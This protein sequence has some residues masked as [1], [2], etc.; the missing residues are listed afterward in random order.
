MNALLYSPSGGGKTTNATLVAAPRRKKNLLICSDNSS[1]VL[2]NFER[3]NLDIQAVSRVQ[4]FLD[5]YQTGAAAKKYDNIIVDN[6]SDLFDM[7]ILEL[8]D[9]KKYKDM[10]QAY[11]LVYQSLKRLTRE[12]TRLD[13]NTVFTAWSNMT[14]ITRPDGSLAQRLE[15]KI[16]SKVLDNIAGL[17]NVVG[18]INTREKDGKRIWYYSLK[19][20]PLVMAKDQIACR[21]WCMPEDLF[22]EEKA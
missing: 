3:P 9:S 11:Q 15:P 20:G 18:Y 10:R 7:W 5:A 8:E 2:K 4:E 1:I 21:D 22:A 12:S 13:C 6:L 14:Q 17:C 19:G 16:P